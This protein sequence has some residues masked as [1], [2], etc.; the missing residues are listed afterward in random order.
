MLVIATAELVAFVTLTTLAAAVVPTTML[1]NPNREGL[2]VRGGLVAPTPVPDTLTTS[3]LNAPP[4]ARTTLPLTVPSHV[5]LKLTFKVHLPPDTRLLAQGAVPPATAEKLPLAETVRFTVETLLFVT[6]STCGAQP[7]PQFT[8]VLPNPMVAGV[9][10]T[11]VTLV[12]E[13]FT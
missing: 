7:A 12:P 13:R 3:G 8:V 6:V 5:G 11:G 2:N 10:E 1:L 9:T 4:K